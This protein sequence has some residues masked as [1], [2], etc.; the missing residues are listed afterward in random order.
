[1]PCVDGRKCHATRGGNVNDPPPGQV[2][3]QCSGGLF[4]DLAP[5]GIRNGGELTMQI[6]H[7]GVL[8]L[9]EPMPSE[10]S[11]TGGVDDEAGAAASGASDTSSRKVAEGTKNRF[12]VTARLKSSSRS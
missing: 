3:L 10:P 11:R 12:P 4:F 5:G 7:W 8:P 6:I 9:S 1:M 2:A